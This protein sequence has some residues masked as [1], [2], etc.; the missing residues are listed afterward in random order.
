MLLCS[1]CAASPQVINTKQ[2]VPEQFLQRREIPALLI[3]P[4][5]VEALIIQL[6]VVEGIV[7]KSNADKEAIRKAM[8]Q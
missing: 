1:S 5:T 4:V 6:G 8:G 2:R 7:E 3:S